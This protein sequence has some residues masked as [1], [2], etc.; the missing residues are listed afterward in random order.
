M[1]NNQGI[2]VVDRFACG[3]PPP[4]P[5]NIPGAALGPPA[6]PAPLQGGIAA[7]RMATSPPTQ[8]QCPNCRQQIF[9]PRRDEYGY[10]ELLMDFGAGAMVGAI[11]GIVCITAATTVFRHPNAK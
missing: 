3:D 4:S 7:G 5:I 11:L 9:L 8:F 2:G 6:P 1:D 10:K